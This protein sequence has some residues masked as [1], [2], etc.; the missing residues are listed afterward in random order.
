[1]HPHV[2]YFYLLTMKKFFIFTLLTVGML[3]SCKKEETT[4]KPTT[5]LLTIGDT[6]YTLVG[7]AAQYSSQDK[8]MSLT[9]YPEGI[10]TSL[11]KRALEGTGAGVFLVFKVSNKED[12]IP[13]GTYSLQEQNLVSASYTQ[14]TDYLKLPTVTGEKNF[15][16]ITVDVVY[17]SPASLSSNYELNFSGTEDN[18]TK[19][20]GNIKKAFTFDP[21]NKEGTTN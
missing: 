10:T 4:T 7:G 3:S 9:L 11:A 8:T 6:K 20:S 1:M 5:S 19:V 2:H 17:S 12:G 18:G 13:R 14:S 15:K 16:S 21:D